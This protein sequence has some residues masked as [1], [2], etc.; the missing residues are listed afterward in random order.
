MAVLVKVALT[1]TAID[2]TNTNVTLT[3]SIEIGFEVAFP[4]FVSSI[5]PKYI[6]LATAT[7]GYT[8]ITGYDFS[9]YSDF[10]CIFSFNTT[11]S[12]PAMDTTYYQIINSNR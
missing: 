5:L 10:E 7:D 6:D 9:Y 2:P 3:V 8:T 1:T 4:P 12:V 11:Y